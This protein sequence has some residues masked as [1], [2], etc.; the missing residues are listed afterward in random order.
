MESWSDL[1]K[2]GREKGVVCAAE[3]RGAVVERVTRSC[4]AIDMLIEFRK[5]CSQISFVKIPSYNKY[6]LGI[7]GFLFA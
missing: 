4:T 3:V 1:P 2:G 7:Y 6:S 5:P